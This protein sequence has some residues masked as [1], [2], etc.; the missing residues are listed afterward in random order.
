MKKRVVSIVMAVSMVAATMG[1]GTTASAEEV[2][3][4]RIAMKDVSMENE[5]QKAWMD[6]F[7][8]ALQEAGIMA[9]LEVVEMQSGTYS[10]NL[11]LMLNS[12]DIPDIIYFQGGDQVFSDQ[13]VMSCIRRPDAR[14]HDTAPSVHISHNIP[15]HP[16]LPA[17]HPCHHF[18]N[19]LF[20]VLQ[21]PLLS[22]LKITFP[23]FL[24]C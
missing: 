23:S 5:L 20:S 16:A 13:G 18:Q 24:S 19:N 10:D 2:T 14:N 1:L 15:Q 7:N 22:T 6:E 4:L 9:Q 12:G 17:S 21:F 11:A 8:A 3:T